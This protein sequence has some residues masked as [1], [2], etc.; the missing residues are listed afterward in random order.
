MGPLPSIP[1]PSTALGTPRVTQAPLID[2]S[3]SED[4]EHSGDRAGYRRPRSS[5]SILVREYIVL[6]KNK[7]RIVYIVLSC[8]AMF[9]L[10]RPPAI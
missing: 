7:H 5:S 3:E 9:V 1:R 2:T 6:N 8:I 4:T 10:S